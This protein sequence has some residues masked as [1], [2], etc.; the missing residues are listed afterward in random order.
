MAVSLKCTSATQVKYCTAE[1]FMEEK[2]AIVLKQA[3]HDFNFTICADISHLC[4]NVFACKDFAN[5]I[6]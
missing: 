1:G 6:S 2:F 3:F 5:K 4:F